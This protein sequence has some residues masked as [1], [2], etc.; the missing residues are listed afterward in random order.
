MK[1]QLKSRNA[2]WLSNVTLAGGG[3]QAYTLST[4]GGL[5]GFEGTS[6]FMNLTDPNCAQFGT[7]PV[8]FHFSPLALIS[9][10]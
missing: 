8:R 7:A 10:Y 1:N 2:G 3:D 9:A 4:L 6:S 5:Q